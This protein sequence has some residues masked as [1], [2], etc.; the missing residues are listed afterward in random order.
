M[1]IVTLNGQTVDWKHAAH[2][3]GIN[4]YKANPGGVITKA[5]F[6]QRVDCLKWCFS[7]GA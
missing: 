7:H 5:H 3:Y 2:Y 6:S 1:T 4:D